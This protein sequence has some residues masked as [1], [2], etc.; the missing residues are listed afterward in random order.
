MKGSYMEVLRAWRGWVLGG[1]RS[2]MAVPLCDVVDRAWFEPVAE[3]RLRIGPLTGNS[4]DL[5]SGSTAARHA[6]A[7]A[8]G[9]AG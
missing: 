2:S 5:H 6:P 4:P 9:Q 3:R 7:V 1:W 8:P